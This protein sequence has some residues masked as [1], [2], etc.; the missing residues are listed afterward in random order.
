MNQEIRRELIEGLQ[1]DLVLRCTKL[2]PAQDP[3][4]EACYRKYLA[5]LNCTYQALVDY[6]YRRNS[7]V[8]HKVAPRN[9]LDELLFWNS[10]FVPNS[11]SP[12]K[13]IDPAGNETFS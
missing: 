3:C 7:K 13:E 12:S 8:A 9:D 6:G 1:K 2:C 5:A 11:Y 10:G 4:F